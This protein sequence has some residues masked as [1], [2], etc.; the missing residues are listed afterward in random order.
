MAHRKNVRACIPAEG[1]ADP[2]MKRHFTVN[3]S[4]LVLALCFIALTGLGG[5]G[6]YQSLHPPPVVQTG[7]I[8]ASLPRSPG[9]AA[10]SPTLTQSSV[11][12]RASSTPQAIVPSLTPSLAE[13]LAEANRYVDAKDYAKALPLLQQ[14]ADAGS[15]EAL[16][17]LGLLYMNGWGV[18]QDYAKAFNRFLRAAELGNSYAMMEVGRLYIR[19]GTKADDA[20][21]FRWLNQAYAAPKRN[22]EAGA[23]IG[24]CYLSG[25][26]TNQDVQKAEEIVMPLANQGVVPAMTL[27]GR[28]L[29]YKADIKRTEAAG[30]EIQSVGEGP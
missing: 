13:W 24:D 30:K 17:S 9:M 6:I 19:T 22:L 27:A 1:S 4:G 16:N 25:K 26:G 2:S 18:V 14:A 15:A 10:K 5:W 11:L 28:I 29:Q 12:P 20:E 23:L 7:P 3:I 8:P 21:G